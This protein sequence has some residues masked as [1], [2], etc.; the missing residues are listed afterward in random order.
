MNVARKHH[1]V[2]QGYL[3]GFTNDGTRNGQ[4]TVFDLKL[5]KTFRTTPSNVAA[6]RDF[7]RIDVDGLLPDALEQSLGEFEGKAISSIRQLQEHG[8]CM[9]DDERS[10]IVTL[11]TLLVVRNPR[12]RR[13]ITDAR[14]NVDRVLR[15]ILASDR[16]MYE[17]HF[18]KAK[19]D[20]AI[21]KDAD[22][23]F[24]QAAAFIE[25]D[26]SE[27]DVSTT[28]SISLELGNFESTFEMPASRWWSLVIADTEAPDFVTCDHPVAIVYKDPSRCGPVGYGLP[29]TEVSFPLGPRHAVIG[30]LENPLQSQ[31][32]VRTDEVAALNSRTVDYADR[33]VYATSERALIHQRGGIAEFNVL[34][35]RQHR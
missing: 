21:S 24:E 26:Q 2:P 32:T 14:R 5:K 30:V 35:D 33:H 25:S 18:A 12:R 8:G 20:G 23:P 29:G 11:M 15:D 28:E 4:L 6:K 31:F 22:L 17:H 27:F 7:N 3:A 16:G 13:R 34:G 10:D 1:F 9:T 19:S